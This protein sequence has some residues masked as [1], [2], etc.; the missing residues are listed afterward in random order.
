MEKQAYKPDSRTTTWLK[1]SAKFWH[2]T[3][4]PFFC[5]LFRTKE[6]LEQ[7]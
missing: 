2:E 6:M 5:T 4:F 1:D 3:C 7:D